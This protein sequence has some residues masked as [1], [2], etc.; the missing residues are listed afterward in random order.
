M[1]IQRQNEQ[2]KQE[3]QDTKQGHRSLIEKLNE[4]TDKTR[5]LTK[6]LEES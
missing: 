6:K 3:L 1:E 4:E 2:M 5:S